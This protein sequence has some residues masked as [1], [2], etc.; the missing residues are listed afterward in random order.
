MSIHGLVVLV[1]Y[2]LGPI[3]GLQQ[4]LVIFGHD[5]FAPTGPTRQPT[6]GC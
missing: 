5:V 6:P 3:P 2:S 4:P 1:K